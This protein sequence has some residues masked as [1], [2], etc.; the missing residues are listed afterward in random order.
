MKIYKES[1][2]MAPLILKTGARSWGAVDFTPMPFYPSKEYQYALKR[3][4]GG[5]QNWSGHF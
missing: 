5:P 1:R 3:R 2:G 4:L